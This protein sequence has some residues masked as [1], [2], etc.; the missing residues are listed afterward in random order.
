MPAKPR[1]RGNRPAV[2][3]QPLDQFGSFFFTFTDAAGPTERFIL[4]YRTFDPPA[5]ADDGAVVALAHAV[6]DLGETQLGGF[7]HQVHGD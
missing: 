3:F 5:G 7:S 1:S 2:F 6:T 4:G